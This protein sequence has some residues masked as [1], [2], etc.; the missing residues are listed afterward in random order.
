VLSTQI[1]ASRLSGAMGL[2]YVET[3]VLAHKRACS[4][5]H[6][7]AGSSAAAST[8]LTGKGRASAC[9]DSVAR[10][11]DRRRLLATVLVMLLILPHAMVILVAFARDGAWTTQVLPPEYTL[12]N[13]RRLATDSRLW[14]PIRNSVSMAALA[15]A[16]NVVVCFLAAYLIVCRRFRGRGL[17]TVLVALPWAIPATAIAI[18]LAATFSASLCCPVV[19]C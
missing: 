14:V 15:T 16:A 17:L 8:R 3:T 12:D 7:C 1:F 2:A 18:G 6:C 11:A 13:F 19:Y 4:R 5:W 9:R 10:G